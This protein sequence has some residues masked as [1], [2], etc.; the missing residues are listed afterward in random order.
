MSTDPLGPGAGGL[1]DEEIDRMLAS[2]ETTGPVG[3]SDSDIDDMLANGPSSQ[4]VGSQEDPGLF[5][6]FTGSFNSSFSRGVQGMAPGIAAGLADLTG[7]EGMFDEQVQELQAITAETS[8]S[9]PNPTSV[10]AVKDKFSIGGI[11][12]AAAEVVDLAVQGVGGSLGYMAPSLALLGFGTAA[13]ASSAAAA[14][15]VAAAAMG[16][17]ALT[18]F[19]QYFSEQ[20]ETSY[21]EA[22]ADGKEVDAK[23]I[24][25]ANQMLSAAGQTLLESLAPAKVLKGFNKS[26]MVRGAANTAVAKTALDGAAKLGSPTKL[27]AA[28]DVVGTELFTEQ[29][30]NLLQ[31]AAA[32]QTIDP[33]DQG[34]FDSYVETFVQTLLVAGVFGGAAAGQM[35]LS[36]NL[37]AKALAKA[38]AGQLEADQEAAV[39]DSPSVIKEGPELGPG[40]PVTDRQQELVD[41]AKREEKR[42]AKEHVNKIAK[43]ERTADD[44]RAA[45]ADRN[46]DYDSNVRARAGLGRIVHD[47]A[48]K[49]DLGRATPQELEKIYER[50]A[51]IPVLEERGPIPLSSEYEAVRLARGLRSPKAG[52]SRSRII[53]KIKQKLEASNKEIRINKSF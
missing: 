22:Q 35:K 21:T 19:T 9:N 17:A 7:N 39:P 46:I 14:P 20:I 3:L 48:G 36:E 47:V 12:P 1:T 4:S 10:Q 43:V 44:V 27:R 32:G 25:L 13:T 40:V 18:R 5:D 11:L 51:D 34:A 37:E 26:A 33:S 50:V 8:K 16:G 24:D 23:D 42:R 15:Y 38:E 49:T 31:R 45:L 2:A 29:G 6:R 28:M 53:D 30:Q 52:E 41:N